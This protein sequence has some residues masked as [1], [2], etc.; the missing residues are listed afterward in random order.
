MYYCARMECHNVV[1]STR[2]RREREL[3]LGK[4]LVYLVHAFHG[5]LRRFTGTET[6][7]TSCTFAT[8]GIPYARSTL[9]YSQ[10]RIQFPDRYIPS[11]VKLRNHTHTNWT[12]Q[13]IDWCVKGLPAPVMFSPASLPLTLAWSWCSTRR[14]PR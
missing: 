12:H 9:V 8:F 5:I 14:R 2:R 7:T 11:S 3:P 4:A 13:N 10:T 1:K 6:L